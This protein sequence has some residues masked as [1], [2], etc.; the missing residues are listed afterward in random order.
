MG[1][2]TGPIDANQWLREFGILVGYTDIYEVVNEGER[3]SPERIVGY[4][5]TLK[6]EYANFHRW[7]R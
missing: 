2:H 4:Y 3:C 1:I 7:T 6:A 5:Q